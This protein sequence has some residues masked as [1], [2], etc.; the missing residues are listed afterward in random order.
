MPIR[1]DPFRLETAE[2]FPVTE[3]A[4]SSGPHTSRAMQN[5]QKTQKKSENKRKSKNGQAHA[6]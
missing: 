2:G 6:P 3:T 4:P 1:R 5:I